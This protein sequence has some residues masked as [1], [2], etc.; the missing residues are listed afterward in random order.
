VFC[1]YCRLQLSSYTCN[2]HELVKFTVQ[3]RH[4]T[5]WHNK[6]ISAVIYVWPYTPS[7]KLS[8]FT[9]IINCKLACHH[10]DWSHELW[11]VT[12][13][14]SQEAETGRVAG[15]CGAEWVGRLRSV[16]SFCPRR[17]IA[18]VAHIT[19]WRRRI[20]WRQTWSWRR[21]YG[22]CPIAV[23]HLGTFLRSLAYNA[24]VP[25]MGEETSMNL[26]AQIMS[27]DIF[28]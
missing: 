19:S 7:F 5:F 2:D 23:R 27:S 9:I 4:R 25:T 21:R 24:W 14:E 1:C 15:V 6:M 22:L 11:Q 26:G 10:C 8:F 16:A 28:Q 13:D 3:K 12:H 17:R 18:D 20:S